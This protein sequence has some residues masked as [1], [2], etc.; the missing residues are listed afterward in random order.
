MKMVPLYTGFS[1]ISSNSI[2][3]TLQK[4][5]YP[6]IF[7]S[8]AN[9]TRFLDVQAQTERE[10][11]K[12]VGFQ[13]LRSPRNL[14]GPQTNSDHTYLENKHGAPWLHSRR[15]NIPNEAARDCDARIM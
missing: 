10:G 6:G 2:I 11:V 9:S 7:T 3:P 15:P 12:G 14:R 8:V 13:D 1:I 4:K 5:P